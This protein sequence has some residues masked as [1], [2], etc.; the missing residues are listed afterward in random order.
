MAVE[1][2]RPTRRRQPVDTPAAGAQWTFTNHRGGLYQV[3]HITFAFLTS[4]VVANRLPIL[5]AA[6]AEDTWF[7]T[8]APAAVPANS[9]VNF[10]G[11]P[12]SPPTAISAALQLLA[13]PPT[14]LLLG[15]GHVLSSG[16][17]ALDGGDL[18]ANIILDGWEYPET[19]PEHLYPLDSLYTEDSQG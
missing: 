9:V 5:Q 7:R 18:F 1:R 12:D 17:A 14:G 8:G 3:H 2:W 6:A 15:P 13:W 11:W 10:A 16:F 19:L 4:A